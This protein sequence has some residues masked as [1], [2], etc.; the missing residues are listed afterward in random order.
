MTMTEAA[1]LP[2][3]PS[4]H[5]EIP[6][7]FGIRRN[8]LVRGKLGARTLGPNSLRPWQHGRSRTISSKPGTG[9]ETGTRFE[10]LPPALGSRI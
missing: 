6:G 2:W 7:G 10:S 8:D 4:L 3:S 9:Q 5:P 1:P